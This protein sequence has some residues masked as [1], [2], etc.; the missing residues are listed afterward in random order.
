MISV[1]HT[2]LREY[3]TPNIILEVPSIEQRSPFFN[4]RFHV[5][6]A[7]EFR[8]EFDA[9]VEQLR[10][11]HAHREQ[12]AHMGMRGATYLADYT[13]EKVGEV[14]LGCLVQHYDYEYQS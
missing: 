1:R 4:K 10:Y 11:A 13:W 3:L 14:A 7:T 9:I 8:P 5:T 6:E 12:I 2:G